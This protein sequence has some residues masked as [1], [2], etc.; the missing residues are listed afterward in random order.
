MMQDIYAH[1]AMATYARLTWRIYAEIQFFFFLI[2]GLTFQQ[3]DG[4]F[5]MK[6]I[7]PTNSLYN[8]MTYWPVKSYKFGLI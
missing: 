4:Q 7:L 8:F 5:S 6:C 3:I 1:I 2:S